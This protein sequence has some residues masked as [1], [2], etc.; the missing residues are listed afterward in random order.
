MKYFQR[1][2]RC[3]NKWYGYEKF[4][5]FFHWAS[6]HG[7]QHDANNITFADMLFQ[8]RPKI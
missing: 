5:L 6:A 8:M 4:G 1:N 3:C 2:T 7:N